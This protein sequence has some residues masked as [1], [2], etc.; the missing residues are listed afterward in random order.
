MKVPIFLIHKVTE[1][2][3]SWGFAYHLCIVIKFFYFLVFWSLF[4]PSNPLLNICADCHAALPFVLV[5]DRVCC[6]S[7]CSH[8]HSE[9]TVLPNFEGSLDQ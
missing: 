9:T 3:V 5:S 4:L 7:N 2:M 8:S 6:P 1:P